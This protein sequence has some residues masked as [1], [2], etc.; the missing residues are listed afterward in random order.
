VGAV[1]KFLI[2]FLSQLVAYALITVNYRY[3]SQGNRMG[4]VTSDGMIGALNFWLIQ[5]IAKT[6][7][8]LEW[9][10]YTLGCMLGSL[11]GITLSVH[12]GR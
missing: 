10:G 5:R 4:A 12:M 7:T 9:V 2:L 11:L 6:E 3:I 1:K 8:T